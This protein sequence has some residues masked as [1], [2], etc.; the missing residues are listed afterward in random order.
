MLK[1]LI[2]RKI[3]ENGPIPFDDFMQMALYYPDLGYYT[4]ADTKIG[5]QGDFFT[6]S[7]LGS[8]FGLILSRQ[9]EIFYQK[10]NCPETLTITEI[11]PGMGFLAKD[12]LESIEPSIRVR[13]NLVEINP[14][15]QKIQRERLKEHNN[16][17]F[18]YSSIDELN[19][20]EGLIICNEVFD[21][22]PVRVFEVN[23]LGEVMEVYVGID[24]NEQII[25]ILLPC[26]E[27]TLEYLKDFAPWVLNI[28]GYRSEV[29]LSMKSLIESLS[30]KLKKGYILIFDYGYT[31][32]EYYHPERKRGTLLCYHKH[33]INENPYINI[34][35]QDITCHVNFSA[36]EKFAAVFGF[37]VERYSSQGSYLI[38]LCDEEILKKIYQKDLKEHFKRLILPQG[39]GES[40]RVMILRK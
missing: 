1:D 36:V 37:K 29:N 14:A 21:A 30:R 10:L 32:E 39:M 4:K 2:I 18:W 38:S 7:H 22:L 5:R 19:S 20:F 3:K 23:D 26:R 33:N 24:K 13:Y 6:A 12:V 15:L 31:S 17:I 9:I 28:K 27:D 35:Y 25:E 8:V 11:G 34:G 16:K 40:H